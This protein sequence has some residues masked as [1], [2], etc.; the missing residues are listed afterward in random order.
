[1]SW[2]WTKAFAFM[3]I[4]EELVIDSARPS[5][6]GMKLLKSLVVHPANDLGI[7]ATHGGR[8]TPVYPS[9]KRLGLRVRRWL[10]PS[11]HLDLIPVFISIIWSRRRSEFSLQS[12]SIWKWSEQKE[13]LELIE[14][15]W[16]S[17]TGFKQLSKDDAFK[18]E[19]LLNLVVS[20]PVGNLFKPYPLSQD[21]DR[22]ASSQSLPAN[23]AEGRGAEGAPHLTPRRL[24]F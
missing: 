12:L 22:S 23:S 20:R 9:L 15:S 1:M 16:I 11:E 18:R 4:L 3:S 6:C 8:N 21:L 17:L 5:S 24:S 14:G 2:A 13:P 10:R 19:G 7:S